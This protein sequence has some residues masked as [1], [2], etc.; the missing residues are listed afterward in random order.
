MSKEQI[1][2][3]IRTLFYFLFGIVFT[4]LFILISSYINLSNDSN[5]TQKVQV[6][7]LLLDGINIRERYIFEEFMIKN[8]P[9][10]IHRIS[11]FLDDQKI[12]NFM[13]G[14][15][16][17]RK[18]VFSNS[19]CSDVE[20]I[21]TK[22]GSF[23]TTPK[24]S[25]VLSHYVMEL[26]LIGWGSNRGNAVIVVPTSQISSSKTFFE[27]FFFYI[28]PF[29]AL[30]LLAFLI[31]NFAEK[32]LIRPTIK[33]IIETEKLNTIKDIVSQF[34]HDIR[35]PLAVL[36]MAT[37]TIDS[38]KVSSIELIQSAIERIDG[39][40][41]DLLRTDRSLT[42][43]QSTDIHLLLKDIVADKKLEFSAR[44]V[45]FLLDVTE[46]IRSVELCRNDLYR[47]LSNLIN[48]SIEAVPSAATPMIGIRVF[49]EEKT[50]HLVISDNGDGIEE[51]NMS[52]IILGNFTTKRSGNGLGV[53]GCIK[54]LK[55]FKGTLKLSS[56][57]GIGTTVEMI[58]PSELIGF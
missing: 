3:R 26:P 11:S 56:I 12:N 38:D 21:V 25:E 39:I 22:L 35:S 16:E 20:G 54:W 58:L 34:A 6:E 33:R 17:D 41:N 13:I 8:Y 47:V 44:D 43:E 51:D 49:F 7:R 50:L 9:A 31:F 2:L 19:K 1:E 45:R 52:R 23:S 48:N 36:N 37:Q 57:K 18:C 40:S 53:S 42:K 46:S 55:Q 5:A 4:G 32:Q 10:V 15:Y 30:M 24:G 29:A 14:I 27:T 28:I